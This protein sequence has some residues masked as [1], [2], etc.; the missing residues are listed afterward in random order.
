MNEEVTDEPLDYVANLEVPKKEEETKVRN[1]YSRKDF[2]NLPFHD[3]DASIF[4]CIKENSDN[5]ETPIWYG[6][7]CKIKDC[8]HLI[9]LSFGIRDDEMYKNS[10]YKLDTMIQHLIEFK[11]ALI[12]EKAHYE[13][14]LKL[15]K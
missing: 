9:T 4:T 8:T 12:K 3:S 10:L 15:K 7:D 2:L 5:S 11:D 13:T 6:I 1:V 14:N